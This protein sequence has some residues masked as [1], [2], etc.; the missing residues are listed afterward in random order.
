[1]NTVNKAVVRVKKLNSGLVR[2]SMANKPFNFFFL[3]QPVIDQ[4]GLAIALDL[5][6]ERQEKAGYWNNWE[7][8]QAVRKAMGL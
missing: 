6:I 2:Y 1:M 7:A 5:Y 8:A 3:E 4:Y